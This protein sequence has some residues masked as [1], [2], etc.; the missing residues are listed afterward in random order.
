[1]SGKSVVIPL[2]PDEP[3]D[4]EMRQALEAANLTKENINGNMGIGM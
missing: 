3:T 2:K 1:M 4:A